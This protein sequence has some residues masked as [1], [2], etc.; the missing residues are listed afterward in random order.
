M[1]RILDISP[2]VSSRIGVWPGD[3]PYNR[4]VNLS[5]A[6]GANI[7]LSSIQAT[8]HLGAHTDAP[9]HYAGDGVGIHE[10]PLNLYLGPCQIMEVDLPRHTRI[11]PEH[12]M[13]PIRAPRILFKTGSFPDPDQFTTDFVSLSAPLIEFLHDRKVR[14]VGLDTPSI[15]LFE[16]KVLESHQVVAR[17]DMAILEGVVLEHVQPGLYTLIALPLKL[18]DADASPVRAVLLDSVFSD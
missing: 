2:V 1:T 12:L 17:H 8:V 13:D 10:R 11:L 16:D 14:L 5:I 15:D 18:E 6:E 4:Q 7:D 9:N 3:V